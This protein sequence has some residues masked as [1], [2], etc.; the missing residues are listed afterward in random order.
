MTRVRVLDLPA[1]KLDG[2]VIVAFIFED[3]QPIRGAAALLDWRLCGLLTQNLL[4]GFM[5]GEAGQRLVVMGDHRVNADWVMF[6]GAGRFQTLDTKKM[7]DLV[8]QV[9]DILKRA[10]F[11]RVALAITPPTKVSRTALQGTIEAYL[12]SAS[13][14]TMECLLTFQGE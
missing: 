14:G 11:R 3:Q 5:R 9:L 13:L 4:E 1:D 2:E 6:F 12:A 10:G 8:R 7:E